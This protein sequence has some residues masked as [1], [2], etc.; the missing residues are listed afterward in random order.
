[1]ISKA[2]KNNSYFIALVALAAILAVISLIFL[3]LEFVWFS[4]CWSN[5]ILILI[6]LIFTALFVVCVFLKTRENASLFTS[7]AMQLYLTYLTW[8]ALASRPTDE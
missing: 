8:T 6:P 7:A 3:I 1:M 4:G 2:E 5:N